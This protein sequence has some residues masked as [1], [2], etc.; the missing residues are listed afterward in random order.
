[1]VRALMA[2]LIVG[3]VARSLITLTPP[4]V[5]GDDGA[6]YLVQVR[7]ILR[8]GALA[9]PDFPLLFYVQAC[10]A[11]LFSL[12][13]EQRAAII[14]AVR[15]T[16]TFLPLALA[17]PVFLFA[18]AFVRPGDRPAQGAA[19]VALVGLVAVASGNT[20]L[21]G[22]GMIKNAVA[23]PSSFLFASASH[24][25]L[26]GGHS[27]TLV[28]PV[29]WFV[30]ASLTHMSGLVLSTALA[31]G[32]LAVGLATPA[33]RPRVRLPAILLVA[34]LGCCFAIVHAFDPERAQRLVHAVITPGWLFAESPA[35]LWLR[36]IS[37][38]ALRTI[39]TSAEVWVGNALG[40][41]GVVTLFRHRAG[42][43]PATR[44]L[45]LASTLVTLAFSSPLI[46]P[47]VLQRLA[48]IAYVP[49]MIP[50]VYLA[51]RGP[52]CMRLSPRSRWR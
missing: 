42:M 37:D 13:V 43:D 26:R 31:A 29:F 51:C 40:M 35:L 47:D 46:R 33:T 7:A 2:V 28:W 22:G 14:A 24:R 17:V 44:V 36:G 1:M 52:A 32:I 23:L 48:L 19:A 10:V 45:I 15:I 34:S 3:F 25:W 49:G 6:Y 20:L 27:D 9:I 8:G 16:D 12:M 50:L 41:L 5:V 4:L 39:F 38:E 11:G 18:R 21:M 30:L